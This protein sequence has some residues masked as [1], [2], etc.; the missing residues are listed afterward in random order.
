MAAAADHWEHFPHDADIGVRGL[1]A[2]RE[3]AFEQAAMALTAAITDPA[4]VR[5]L[6][7]V[8]VACA[9]PDDETLLVDW[10]NALVFEMAR[11]SM[12]F[13]R[14]AVRLDGC[15]LA[16]SA[17]G[18]PVDPARHRPAVEVKGATYTA[19]SVRQG[20][21]GRWLAQCVVDV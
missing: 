12:L 2:S 9:A 20:P 5:P 18:E 8:A 10:L 7:E 13:G 17:W 19:L 15:A 21:D 6:S 1:G 14:F 3:R 16:A 11:R 4:T